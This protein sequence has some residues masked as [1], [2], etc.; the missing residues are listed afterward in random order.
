MSESAQGTTILVVDDDPRLLSALGE[1]LVDKGWVT[2]V[3]QGGAEALRIVQ[4][5][6]DDIALTASRP[7]LEVELRH[8]H[9]HTRGSKGLQARRCGA[10][11]AIDEAALKGLAT[12]PRAGGRVPRRRA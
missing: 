7:G 10:E 9:E 1:S 2:L 4:S 6:P 3:A 5:Y 11:S 12:G 8:G